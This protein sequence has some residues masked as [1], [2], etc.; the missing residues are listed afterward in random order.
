MHHRTET[1][2]SIPSAKNESPIESDLKILSYINDVK[3]S[4]IGQKSPIRYDDAVAPVVGKREINVVGLIDPQI[5]AKWSSESNA[6]QNSTLQLLSKCEFT[7]GDSGTI[8]S[9]T[10]PKVMLLHD[11]FKL[12]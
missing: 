9:K 7:D 10:N 4:K 12:K 3:D 6:A 5:L 1:L 8:R 11:E 2:L